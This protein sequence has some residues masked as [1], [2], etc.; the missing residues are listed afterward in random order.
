[1]LQA[2]SE[3]TLSS[4][5]FCSA[6]WIYRATKPRAMRNAGAEGRN[7][8]SLQYLLVHFSNLLSLCARDLR[9]ESTTNRSLCYKRNLLQFFSS[10]PSSQSFE[11]SQT[12]PACMQPSFV[13]VNWSG[14]HVLGAIE[15]T[16]VIRCKFSSQEYM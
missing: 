1:M 10:A 4:P 7:P 5:N 8:S 14:P 12:H 11:P 13:Q 9:G 2:D 3:G 6:R 15:G 16:I